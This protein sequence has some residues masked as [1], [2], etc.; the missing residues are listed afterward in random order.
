MTVLPWPDRLKQIEHAGELWARTWAPND[1]QVRAE[2]HRQIMMNLS[3]GYFLYFQSSPDH[4][5]FAPF[6]NSVYLLQPNPDDAYVVA[7]ISGDGIYRI[8]GDRGSVHLLTITIGK[9]MMGMV[10]EMGQQHLEVDV[11]DLVAGKDGKVDIILS[12]E[13]PE[14]HEGAWL[15][16][17]RESEYVLI[18]QRSYDWGNEADARL[19]IERL[20]NNP[21]KRRMPTA[22]IEQRLDGM[23]AFAERLSRFW[24]N[25]V[26]GIKERHAPNSVHVAPFQEMGGVKAQV[27]WEAIFEIAPDEALIVETEV[28]RQVRYWN[29]QLNDEIWNTIEYVNAQ[30]SLNGHQAQLDSDGR[31]RAVVAAED[32]GVPNW[33]DTLGHPTGTLVGRWYR[34]SDAPEPTLR[35]VKLS[36]LRD[37]L[38]LDT[39]VVTPEA[40][41]ESIRARSRGAQQRRRW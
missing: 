34:S 27:Y 4:P 1:E 31:F 18:R 22:E 11:D 7:H 41:A 29:V 23:L 10:E 8:S 28:P 32:P 20:D 17:R 2:L 24:L 21:I 37:Y 25:F 36:E 12:V 14:G 15:Q 33:L 13:K 38:P 35:R 3:L 16:I 40:R 30:S 26:N 9:N 39:P 5:D 19:S 6:L